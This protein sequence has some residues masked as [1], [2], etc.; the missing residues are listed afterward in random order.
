MKT[1]KIDARLQHINPDQVPFT[2]LQAKRLA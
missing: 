1:D 2:A